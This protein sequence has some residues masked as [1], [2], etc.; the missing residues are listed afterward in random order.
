MDRGTHP[1]FDAQGT[2]ERLNVD[3]FEVR[4][5]GPTQ[6][7]S[8]YVGAHHP[9]PWNH[10]LS[11]PDENGIT[12]EDVVGAST[13]Y[14]VQ[15]RSRWGSQPSV[16]TRDDRGDAREEPR[17][18]MKHE[19]L[20]GSPTKTNNY[21]KHVDGLR[22]LAVLP[23]VVYHA[24]LAVSA[25]PTGSIQLMQGGF[26]GV[27]IFFVI[28]GYLITGLLAKE[29]ASDGTISLRKFYERRLRRIGPCLVTVLAVCTF[30][31]S[32]LLDA[33]R[34]RDYAQSLLASLFSVSNYY[35][36][37]TMAEY[38]AEASQLKPLLHTW[39][40]ACEEQYY[41]LVPI[42]FLATM[43]WSGT[44]GTVAVLV[45]A[46]TLSFALA[47]YWSTHALLK[48]F[49]LLPSRFWEMATG[50]VLS[51]TTEFSSSRKPSHLKTILSYVGSACVMFSFLCLPFGENHPG[52][53]TLPAITGSCLLIAFSDDS[54]VPGKV[55]CSPLMVSIGKVSYSL[56]L[57][58][59]PLF[60]FAR[61]WIMLLAA[62]DKALLVA[63]C[64]GLSYASYV[65]IETPFRNR[66]QT[67]TL[68][69]L[70]Y[71]VGTTLLL[72][73]WS[74]SVL[75]RSTTGEALLGATGAA[76]FSKDESGT[77]SLGNGTGLEWLNDT[78]YTWP[79]VESLQRTPV[80]E[81]RNL[82]LAELPA[83]FKPHSQ[84]YGGG[85]MFS[86]NPS[87]LKVLVV[88]DSYSMNLFNALYMHN[89]LY[90]KGSIEFA[91]YGSGPGVMKGMSDDANS[92]ARE[93][94]VNLR[95]T[96]EDF[97]RANIVVFSWRW[98]DIYKFAEPL[99]AVCNL[100]QG[101][102]NKTIIVTGK[103]PEF[104]FRQDGEFDQVTDLYEKYRMSNDYSAA[105]MNRYFFL[106]ADFFHE[107]NALLR[108]AAE[109]CSLDF[110][111]WKPVVCDLLYKECLGV[112][113]S[114][115]PVYQADG[116]H[117][118][119]EGF[120]AFGLKLYQLDWLGVRPMAAPAV[121][122]QDLR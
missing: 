68:A 105:G 31:A 3:G 12:T 69:C 113:P 37:T 4:G 97:R 117:W 43:R 116:A 107:E 103:R 26:Y 104:Y 6:R 40:L 32:I 13:P 84:R 119:P 34:K 60:A 115:M 20:D 16:Y 92:K 118:S 50:G 111:D 41:M 30:M 61:I 59:V 95:T 109:N 102:E 106:H 70:T 65:Y 11:Q 73:V 24:G 19:L 76:E 75:I 110:L 121:P 14:K 48:A 58:H 44:R 52:I 90:A 21:L 42:V 8:T 108:E 15:E 64:V 56:Y 46:G 54:S 122:K 89:E 114:G 98:R 99:S 45:V 66:E 10:G 67:S 85:G 91:R 79:R 100:F 62:G 18:N 49:Y 2:F 23:V 39:S 101:I 81:N 22:A 9:L 25:K 78:T 55:L 71:V 82:F 1:C 63:L 29:F 112:T 36:W 72:M 27:D 57:W 7:S 120:K 28:S 74:G 86:S 53:F 51:L 33:A 17:N 83:K 5:G 93:K 96:E 35:W 88:G 77:R 38:E 47:Q 94:L 87:T 80:S